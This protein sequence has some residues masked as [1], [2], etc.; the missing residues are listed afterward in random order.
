M[1][2]GAGD[3]LQGQADTLVA[4]ATAAATWFRRPAP[5]AL[6]AARTA[7]LRSMGW[8]GVAVKQKK[9]PDLSF[10]LREAVEHASQ[11]IA[12]ADRFGVEPDAELRRAADAVREA[13]KDLALATASKKDSERAGFIVGAKRWALEAERLRRAIRA[14]AHDDPSLPRGLKRETVALRLSSAAEA[15]QQACDAL[16][17]RFVE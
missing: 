5:T 2:K 8:R 11:A 3:S 14:D 1:R 15:V 4:A 13:A 7:R 9:E 6:A 16:T 12:E 10:A 17:A